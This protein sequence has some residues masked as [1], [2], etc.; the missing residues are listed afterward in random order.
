MKV[1]EYGKEHPKNIVLFEC[2]AEPW[3]VF[4]DSAKELGKSYHVYLM[5]ADGHDES[6][7][8]FTSIEDYARDSANWLKEHNVK[9]IEAL[10]GCSMGETTVVRFLF[11]EEIP[12]HKAIIDGGL[13][14]YEYPWLLRKMIL[15]ID[16]LGITLATKCLPIMKLAAPPAKWTPKGEDPKQHYARIYAFEKQHYSLKT[17]RNVFWSTNNYSLPSP[18]PSVTVPITYW[19]GEGEASARRNNRKK[20]REL[21]PQATFK[22]FDGKEHAE[23]LLMY[24]EE[25]AKEVT[26]Y[27]SN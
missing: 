14:P 15:C 5:I 17:I 27:L 6:G 18:L 24:P 25:F 10:Y 16:V 4:E 23:L 19:Y 13:T 22:Q 9:E 21:F 7:K 11:T 1:L 2:T 26:A 20:I 3:W 8:D 12:V